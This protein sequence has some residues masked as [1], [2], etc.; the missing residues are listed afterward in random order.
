AE[1]IE[2]ADASRRLESPTGSSASPSELRRLELAKRT[3]DLIQAG[4]TDGIPIHGLENAEVLIDNQ[5]VQ[6]K[7]GQ[8]VI[9]RAHTATDGATVGDMR[10]SGE[11]GTL[12]WDEQQR[13]FY[14]SD[15]STY[16]TWVKREGAADFD[17]LVSNREVKIGPRDEVRLGSPDGPELR[18]V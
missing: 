4:R 10:V 3:R 1:K 5:K 13:S 11:H 17:R 8:I 18:L 12:R 14:F 2:Q 15:N 9:G 7:D 16:G 6:L